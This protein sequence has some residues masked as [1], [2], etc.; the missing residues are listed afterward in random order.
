MERKYKNISIGTFKCQDH[1]DMNI[2]YFLPNNNREKV[3][4][5]EEC[6]KEGASSKKF[7]LDKLDITTYVEKAVT[8]MEGYKKIMKASKGKSKKKTATTFGMLY[9]EE[10]ETIKRVKE[11][12]EAEKGRLEYCYDKLL[13]DLRSVIKAEKEKALAAIDSQIETIEQNF[14]YYRA[15]VMRYFPEQQEEN[16][17][18][19]EDEEKEDDF[20]YDI[21]YSMRKCTSTEMLNKMIKNV[22]DDLDDLIVFNIYQK[23]EN[24]RLAMKKAIKVL[25]DNLKSLINAKPVF[26]IS[27]DVIHSL[28]MG[29]EYFLEDRVKIEK[30][31]RALRLSNCYFDSKILTTMKQHDQVKELVDLNTHGNMMQLAYRGSLHGMNGPTFHYMVGRSTPTLAL[32]KTVSGKIFGGFT[33]GFWSPKPAMKNSMFS[34]VWKTTFRPGSKSFLFSLDSGVKIHLD[35]SKKEK[36]IYIDRQYGPCFGN[37]DL[38]IIPSADDNPVTNKIVIKHGVYSSPDDT[39]FVSKFLGE[40]P[41]DNDYVVQDIEVFNFFF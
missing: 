19:Q 9:D 16:E 33:D 10:N 28:K 24:R 5:C 32:V 31:I 29:V 8:C 7:Y 13:S 38:W 18:E 6:L 34:G 36:A 2:K 30:P 37:E 20:E 39:S 41:E 17:N 21:V 25:E 40:K 11:V 1:T 3:V 35:P 27:D 23:D 4:L 15:K 22:N 26:S 12:L 14:Y